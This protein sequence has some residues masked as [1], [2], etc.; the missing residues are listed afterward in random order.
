MPARAAL[1]C[2]CKVEKDPKSR[3]IAFYT[4]SLQSATNLLF[5][6]IARGNPACVRSQFSI[7]THLQVSLGLTTT[8]LVR[9]GQILPE[10]GVVQVA[11]AVEVQQRRDAGGLG[12]VTLGLSLVDSVESAVQ[13]G[14]I[15]LVVLGVVELHN[16]AG[17]V[18]FEGAVIVWQDIK[19]C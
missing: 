14:D 13:A 18:G 3:S 1:V 2:F 8:V 12:K 11:T 15:G 6:G 9:R 16:L 4:W 7:E 5:S 19:R 10:E 17:D